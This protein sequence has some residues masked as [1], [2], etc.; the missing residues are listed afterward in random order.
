[1]M[2]EHDK[3]YN[4]SLYEKR[5]KLSK[6]FSWVFGIAT[7][8][9]IVLTIVFCRYAFWWAFL[10]GTTLLCFVPFCWAL[11][12]Y[13]EVTSRLRTNR[14]LSQVENR[15][16]FDDLLQLRIEK[17]LYDAIRK[18]GFRFWTLASKTDVPL[19]GLI[20]AKRERILSVELLK[21]GI[22]YYVGDKKTEEQDILDDEWVVVAYDEIKQ[23]CD[24]TDLLN[25]LS[26]IKI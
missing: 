12:W 20:K 9:G 19:L 24:I 7:I 10:V 4:P 13:A 15:T 21:T 25:Y 3:Q 17:K 26:E 16:I 23:N 14:Y 8:I 5:Q 1:M 11:A 18:Y 2:R 6:I 22:K